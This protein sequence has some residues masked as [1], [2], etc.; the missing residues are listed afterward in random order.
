MT[1]NVFAQ[2]FLYQW[3]YV[4][5]SRQFSKTLLCWSNVWSVASFP[6]HP[7]T[8]SCPLVVGILTQFKTLA[9]S[10]RTLGEYLIL[11]GWIHGDGIVSGVHLSYIASCSTS[12]FELVWWLNLFCYHHVGFD[13]ISVRKKTKKQSGRRFFVLENTIRHGTISVLKFIYIY[14]KDVSNLL[15]FILA[16]CSNGPLMLDSGLSEL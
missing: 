14:L 7:T 6:F 9:L 10:M 3:A 15:L 4:L 11:G 12:Q 5:V 2:C 13:H 16:V 1:L 8:S